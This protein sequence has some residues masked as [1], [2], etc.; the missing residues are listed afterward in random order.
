MSRKKNRLQQA[1]IL[2][3]NNSLTQEGKFKDRAREVL[4][5]EGFDGAK[6]KDLLSLELMERGTLAKV[7]SFKR[8][9]DEQGLP[10]EEALK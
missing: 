1:Q 9:K 10:T 3:A 6:A 7:F 4:K 8:K 2:T 5:Q